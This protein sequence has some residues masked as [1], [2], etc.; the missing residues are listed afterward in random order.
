[1]ATDH[2]LTGSAPPGPSGTN[3]RPAPTS[4]TETPAAGE[5]KRAGISR[6]PSL[7]GLRFLAALTVFVYHLSIPI[8]SLRLLADDR[9]EFRLYRWF[10]QAGGL[11]V[12]F[13]FVLS[14]F[15]LTWSARG[16]DTPAG[17]WRR[18]FVK[19]YP[20]YVVAW[21]LAMALFASDITSDG[22]ALANLF[23]VQVWVPEYYTNF[24]VDPPSW[25]LGVEVVFYLCFPLLLAAFR[26]IDPRHLKYWIGGAVAAV[27]ATPAVAYALF[28]ATPLVPSGQNLPATAYWFTYVLPPVRMVD[29]AL[30]ILVALAVKHGRWRNIGMIPSFVLLGAGYWLTFHMPYFYGQRA[31]MIIPIVL[32]IAA[33]ATADVEGR[34][35][36]FRNRVMV[37][38]GEISFAF[39]L[40]H[41]IVLVWLREQ[42]GTRMFSNTAGFAILAGAAV[43]TVALSWVLYRLVEVP[44]VRRF[45]R[46][47]RAEHPDTA[48]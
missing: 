16:N 20:N 44:L 29:F 45:S 21:V 3:A 38:L 11:G 15:V 14:G 42:L 35:S 1:M 12:S 23:M 19:V 40:L 34:F 28:P 37:W 36:L 8:P 5:A 39:Y 4:A 30:G 13:F 2:V 31:T 48:T 18:R 43:G 32:L 17:F 25:S 7:T 46:S 26:R 10:D 9:T 41:Y 47:R 6:L 24:S 27:W 22:V 33:A